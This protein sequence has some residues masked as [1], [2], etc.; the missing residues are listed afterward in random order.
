MAVVDHF[1]FKR[2]GVTDG[3]CSP[4]GGAKKAPSTWPGIELTLVR[5][6]PLLSN[7]PRWRSFCLQAVLAAHMGQTSGRHPAGAEIYS[8]ECV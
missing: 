3:C 6:V 4:W 5:Y 2:D 1:D 8:E 7:C